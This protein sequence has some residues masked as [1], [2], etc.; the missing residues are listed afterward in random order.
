MPATRH[1]DSGHTV[2]TTC[3]E[4]YPNPETSKASSTKEDKENDGPRQGRNEE[5]NG[6]IPVYETTWSPGPGARSL[7]KFLKASGTMGGADSK[8][9]YW[10]N[11]L[12]EELR[13]WNGNAKTKARLDAEKIPGRTS[14][15]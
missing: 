13:I 1:H 5:I 6:E 12:L 4:P 3:K 11:I 2:T 14:K 15:G 8:A 9:Y 7:D 10:G